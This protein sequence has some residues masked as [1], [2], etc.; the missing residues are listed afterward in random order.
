MVGM[1]AVSR[2]GPQVPWGMVEPGWVRLSCGWRMV[3]VVDLIFIR[4]GSGS[5]LPLPLPPISAKVVL[6][7]LPLRPLRARSI[8]PESRSA[9]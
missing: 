1:A 2:A 5:P 6:L 7:L 3:M 9:S 4:F 8:W